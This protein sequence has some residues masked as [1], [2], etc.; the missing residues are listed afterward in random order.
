VLREE[1]HRDLVA[2]ADLAGVGRERVLL[3]VLVEAAE[4]ADEELEE[5][6]LADAV[7]TD[8]RDL[9]A[10]VHVEGGVL[11]D[12]D[13]LAL[14]VDERLRHAFHAHDVAAGGLVELEADERADEARALRPFRV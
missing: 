7:R 12:D 8:D 1:A 13:L 4:A 10:A 2:P 3:R 6:G 9:L 5:G 11:V 14:V